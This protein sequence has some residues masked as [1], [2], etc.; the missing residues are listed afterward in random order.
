MPLPLVRPIAALCV[1]GRSIYKHLEGVTCYDSRRDMRRFAGPEP[2]IAHPPCRHWSKFLGHQAK[3]LDPKAEMDLGLLCA[4]LV[5]RNG[6]ILE[7]PAGSRLW[8]AA[9]LPMPNEPAKGP[10]FT[11][12]VE[13]SWFGF[14]TR[15]PTWLLIAGLEKTKVP[16]I[17]FDLNRERQM[18]LHLS[19]EQR[20]RTMPIFA[21][22]LCQIARLTN[23]PGLCD[24]RATCCL[25]IRSDGTKT[26]SHDSRPRRKRLSTALQA[27]RHRAKSLVLADSA[28]NRLPTHSTRRATEHCMKAGAGKS[29]LAELCA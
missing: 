26:G 19:K 22:W 21:K 8:N 17:P 2:V 14:A 4:R 7:Q 3:S 16:P 11:C 10:W 12:Y 20:S 1:S 28:R 13:Q 29:R 23:P 27:T 18:P 5:I 6:G 15:K 24:Q 9:G 25:E